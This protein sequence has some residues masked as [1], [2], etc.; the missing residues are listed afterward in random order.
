[1]LLSERPHRRPTLLCIFCSELLPSK[2]S[3]KLLSMIRRLRPLA[4]PAPTTYNP[5]AVSLPMSQ[6]INVCSLHRSETLQLPNA[7]AKGWPTEIDW[8]KV[9][10]RV[11]DPTM[12]KELNKVVLAKETSV[13][14]GFAKEQAEKVGAVMARTAKGQYEVATKSQPG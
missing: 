8:A 5:N 14:F 12:I 9:Q 4:R 1:M 7:L 6:S 11:R 13:F 3:D 2:P 10:R